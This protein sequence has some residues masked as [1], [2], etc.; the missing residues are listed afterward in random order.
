MALHKGQAAAR[1]ARAGS[2]TCRH[3]RQRRR[4]LHRGSREQ[5]TARQPPSPDSATYDGRVH[6]VAEERPGAPDVD[7]EREECTEVMA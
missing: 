4:E 7:A 2:A 6:V 5:L 3:G 1:A